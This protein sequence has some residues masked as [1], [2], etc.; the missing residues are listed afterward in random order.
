MRGRR[1]E[2]RRGVLRHAVRVDVVRRRANGQLPDARADG[3][4]DAG[5]DRVANASTERTYASSVLHAD[6][7][8]TDVLDAGADRC[9]DCAN[10]CAD[11]CA[12]RCADACA[13][14][15]ADGHPDAGPDR[16]ANARA[17]DPGT[18]RDADE[19]A[20]SRADLD[21]DGA[22]ASLVQTDSRADLDPDRCVRRRLLHLRQLLRPGRGLLVRRARRRR[23]RA[24]L[25]YAQVP[26]RLLRVP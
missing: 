3:H 13:D 25:A 18:H 6:D 19:N 14:V 23:L 4:P 5:P 15:A 8:R 17:D 10:T 16:V 1:R 7:R 11:A 22:A 2:P 20:D 21:P 24:R 12:D 9:A 26:R